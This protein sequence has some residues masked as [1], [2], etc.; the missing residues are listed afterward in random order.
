MNDGFETH[1]NWRK[2]VVASGDVSE[3]QG[4][5]VEKITYDE[6][7][8][9]F[10]VGT[11]SVEVGELDDGFADFEARLFDRFR[12]SAFIEKPDRVRWSQPL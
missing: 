3:I 8:L 6:C 9:F 5:L 1:A 11:T 12:L 7:L 10:T 4:G 2:R